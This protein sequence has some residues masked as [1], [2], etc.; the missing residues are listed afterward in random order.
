MT[1]TKLPLVAIIGRTNVGKSTLFNRLVGDKKALTSR[2]A[3]TT[4]DRRF[5]IC[6]WDKQQFTIVDTAGLDVSGEEEIDRLSAGQAEKSIKEADLILFVVD[7]K[8]GLLPQDNQFARIIQK[9]KKP[10]LVVVNKIDSAKHLSRAADFYQLGFK[11]VFAISAKTG[12]GTGDLLDG[13][14]DELRRQFKNNDARISPDDAP[15]YN[16]IKIAIIGKP[17]VGKSSLF[18]KLVGEERAIVSPVPHTTRDSQDMTIERVQNEKT[19]HLTFVDTAGI[20]K[21]RK[22]KDELKE[23]SIER[24]LTAIKKSDICLLLIDASEPITEQDKNLANEI[25]EQN[26][27]LIFIVNKWDLFPNKTTKSD[28]EYA[29]YLHRFFPFL[30]WAPIIFL[31]AKTGAKVEPHRQDDS[32]TR[33]GRHPERAPTSVGASRRVERLV[34]MTIEIFESERQKISQEQLNEFK[35]YLLRRKTPPRGSGF[36]SP[37]IRG[38]KQRGVSPLTF[39]IIADNADNLVFPYRRFIVSA[40]REYFKFPGCGIKLMLTENRI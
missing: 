29:L 32:S 25:L 23:R 28:K 3:G 31:S 21:H 18:N 12:G 33:D 26:K 7:G 5:G 20:I 30:T 6:G 35:R 10:T 34:R 39:E 38:I 27:S 37:Y 4:R 14:L 40:I 22:I 24:S 8:D 16:S 17:N 2:I 19:Y 9:S 13:V 36:M 11:D 15:G 1:Y